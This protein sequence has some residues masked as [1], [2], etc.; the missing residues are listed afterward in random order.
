MS[1]SSSKLR[2]GPLPRVEIVKMTISL[3]VDL[4]AQ[5]DAYARQHQQLHK[6]PVDAATLIP[7]M[8]SAFIERDRGF[9]AMSATTAKS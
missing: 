6:V 3:P 2:L 9:R 1:T 5:L 4:K 8:L 7:H